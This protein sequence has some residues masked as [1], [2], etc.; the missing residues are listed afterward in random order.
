MT[1][2]EVLAYIHKV[3]WRGGAAVSIRCWACLA[4]RSGT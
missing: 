3:D 4:I 1:L 2:D